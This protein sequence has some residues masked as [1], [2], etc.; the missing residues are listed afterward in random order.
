MS[1]KLNPLQ[2]GDLTIKIPIVQGGM[3][4]AVSTA[5]LASAMG[6]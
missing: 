4:V 6:E 2:L 3:G 5:S 1:K